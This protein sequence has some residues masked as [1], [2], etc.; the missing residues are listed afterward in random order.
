MPVRS[1]SDC[2]C[3]CSTGCSNCQPKKRAAAGQGPTGA[4]GP[5]GAVT[6]GPTGPTGLGVTGPT[7]PFGGPPGPTGPGGAT[8][9]TGPFGGP[10]GPTGATGVVLGDCPASYLE[11]APGVCLYFYDLSPPGGATQ[12]TFVFIHGGLNNAD[13]WEYAADYL[14]NRGFRVIAYDLRGFGRSDRPFE[15]YD[16]TTMAN[17]LQ[18]LLL[19]RGATDITL[20]GHSLGSAIARRYIGVHGAALVDELILL[21]SQPPAIPRLPQPIVDAIIAASRSDKAQA[22]AF[23][24]DSLL[25]WSPLHYPS[26]EFRRQI[27]DQTVN[28]IPLWAFVNALANINGESNVADDASIPP[29]L[30]ACTLIIHGLLDAF[31][32]ISGAIATQASIPGSTLLVYET[33]GHNVWFEEKD[34]FHL[35]IEQWAI[36]CT[37]RPGVVPG[38]PLTLPPTLPTFTGFTLPTGPIITEVPVPPLP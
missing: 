9:A 36:N 30:A 3:G 7:G 19:Q 23:T 20:V 17:D 8:G 38:L 15:G 34:R 24:I 35:D 5:T 2:D 13:M 33:S 10:P 4:T 37:L 16:L 12:G 18:Q 14:V 22:M 26:D 28:Q 1:S 32:P 21:G 31:A 11:V 29:A 6:F 27:K 25:L